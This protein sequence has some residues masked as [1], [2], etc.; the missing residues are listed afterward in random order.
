MLI[1]TLELVY[2]V[3][4]NRHSQPFLIWQFVAKLEI[5]IFHFEIYDIDPLNLHSFARFCFF[6]LKY[7]PIL[8]EKV[9]HVD[10]KTTQL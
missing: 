10:V 5:F 3:M 8:D 1:R 2:I 9:T 4:N 6:Y 7:S